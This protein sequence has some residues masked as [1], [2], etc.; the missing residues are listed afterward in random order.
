M[1][2]E[3]SRVAICKPSLLTLPAELYLAD[4][5][6]PVGMGTWFALPL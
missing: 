6:A 1:V 5:S 4:S 2:L 3:S